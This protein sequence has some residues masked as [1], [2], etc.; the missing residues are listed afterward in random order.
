MRHRKRGR[1]LGVSQSHR[2]ALGRNMVQAL[3]DQ[4][5]IVTTVEKAKQFQ[6]LAERVLHLGKLAA[7]T[8]EDTDENRARKLNHMRRAV[9][10]GGNRNLENLVE[11]TETAGSGKD[12]V[13]KKRTIA[14]TTLQK[15]VKDLGPRNKDRDGGYTRIIR[16]ARRRVGDNASQ[17][18][19]ELTESPWTKVAKGEGSKTEG[20]KTESAK[21]E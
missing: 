18:I 17:C 13:V 1:K 2:K 6:P 11:Q 9:K 5:R 8:P 12:E 21:G 15:L 10:L 3:I 19:L 20:A 16:L 14:R 7:A 4:E